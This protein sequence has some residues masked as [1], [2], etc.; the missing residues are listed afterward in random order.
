MMPIG[1]V[2]TQYGKFVIESNEDERKKELERKN[3]FVSIQNP[4]N[5]SGY[6]LSV[7][8]TSTSPMTVVSQIDTA[9][10]FFIGLEVVS[11]AG[12]GYTLY[13]SGGGDNS[14]KLFSVNWTGGIQ[15]AATPARITILPTL[16]A[17]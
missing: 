2:L 11:N 7:L 15:A 13:A 5:H 16:P 17:P 1:I 4:K 14:I 10:E 6:S 3:D 8:D 12:G 9:G